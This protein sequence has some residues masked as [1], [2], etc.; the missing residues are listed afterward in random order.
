MR[1][2]Q[3]AKIICFRSIL[4]NTSRVR[5]HCLCFFSTLIPARLEWITYTR[6]WLNYYDVTRAM[7]ESIGKRRKQTNQRTSERV[8]E[9]I[10]D[11]TECSRMYARVCRPSLPSIA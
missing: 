9:Q 5:S 2:A 10:N 1:R 3:L 6:T 4:R 8:N 11:R 7:S